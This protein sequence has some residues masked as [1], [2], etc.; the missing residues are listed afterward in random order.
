MKIEE[1]TD[2][3]LLASTKA[4]AA[5]ERRATAALDRVLET[6]DARH[7]GMRQ[8]WPQR[9][10]GEAEATPASRASRRRRSGA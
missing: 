10:E 7:P 9:I 6:I 2:E 1:M 4:Y 5:R 8:R 3:Q